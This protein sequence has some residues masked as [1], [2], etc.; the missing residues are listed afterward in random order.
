MPKKHHH[1]KRKRY[2]IREVRID[3]T[4]L[5]SSS[6]TDPFPFYIKTL[7]GKTLTL[8]VDPMETIGDVKFKIEA[9]EGIPWDQQRLMISG[10][11]EELEDGFTLQDYHIGPN[12]TLY[13][14]LRLP[15]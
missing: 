5:S 4:I 2:E 1:R 14:L 11:R 10:R 12:S 8:N 6:G 3:P 13:L 7:T 15:K 9:Q